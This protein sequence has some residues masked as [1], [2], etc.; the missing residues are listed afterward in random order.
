MYVQISFV[1]CLVIWKSKIH[2]LFNPLR[3][4][5][6]QICRLSNSSWDVERTVTS[7][8]WFIFRGVQ[9]LTFDLKFTRG[10]L[11][12][13]GCLCAKF[14]VCSAN[15][16]F[17]YSL[18]NTSDICS[19]LYSIPNS[20]LSDIKQSNFWDSIYWIWTLIIVTE[21]YPSLS[22]LEDF[23]LLC[24]CFL[25]FYNTHKNIWISV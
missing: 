16:V 11:L 23:L 7:T 20:P 6:Y 12:I 10:Q 4:P 5:L 18:D 3:L 17:I 2:V 24:L 19:I 25:S 22:L 8:L 13:R 1:L 9:L 14:E 15:S 21:H